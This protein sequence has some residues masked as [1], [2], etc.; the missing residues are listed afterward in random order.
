MQEF[1]RNRLTSD[2]NRVRICPIQ[3][4]VLQAERRRPR[5]SLFLFQACEKL[6]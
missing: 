2:L 3:G 5:P 6:G 4:V 1:H